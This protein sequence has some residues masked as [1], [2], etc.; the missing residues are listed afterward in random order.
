M[1][2]SHTHARGS[3]ATPLNLA[4]G[5]AMFG[6]ATPISKIVTSA[7]PVFVGA[8]LRVAIGAL[9]L[10]PAL[11]QRDALSHLSRKDWLMIA[12]LALIGM[13]GFSAFMLYGMRMIGGVAGA[14]VMSTTP[15]VT[16]AASMLFMGDKPTWRKLSA[17]ALAAA[18]VLLLNLG[19][20]QEDRDNMLFGV[21]LVFAAVCCEA[22]YTLIGKAALDHVEP[23]L[24]SFLAAALATPLFLPLAVWQWSSFDVA[25]VSASAWAAVIW[26]GAGTLALGS[27]LWYSGLEYAQGAIAAGFMGV[28]PTSAL[29]LSYVLL[30]EAFRWIHIGGFAVVFVGLLLVSWE[31][32]RSS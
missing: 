6:S 28:M 24:L 32:A 13:F 10:S 2:R 17:I 29:I 9:V 26:Y 25:S 21:V 1:P 8:G 16:A 23:L 11:R 15:A 4:L 7:M 31:H 18:G 5:M 12:L 20:G 3:A 22:C 27:W 30:D 14:V 19:G